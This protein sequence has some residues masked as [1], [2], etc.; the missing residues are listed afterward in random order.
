MAVTEA[1]AKP[2]FTSA[3]LRAQLTKSVERI[4][5]LTDEAAKSE[6]VLTYLRTMAKFHRYSWHNQMLI[7]IQKPEAT[8]VAGFRTW[9]KMSR[10]V[11]KGEKGS[12]SCAR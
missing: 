11:Q 2:R 4:A 9:Q 7:A 6:E 8:K 1:K 3:D 10:F 5:D 12:L